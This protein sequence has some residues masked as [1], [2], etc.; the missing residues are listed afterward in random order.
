MST[1]L[2]SFVFCQAPARPAAGELIR[3]AVLDVR[4][5][6]MYNKMIGSGTYTFRLPCEDMDM[7]LDATQSGNGAQL[8][9]H[10]CSPNCFST[11]KTI[12][13]DTGTMHKIIIISRRD[14]AAG[15]ELTYD[16]RCSSISLCICPC[17]AVCL[18]LLVL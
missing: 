10:S 5:K 6:Q 7:C 11:V 17:E 3:P 13:F 12:Q 18:R 9:N 15:E 14:I 16:Y 4:E 2:T 8:L 1:T